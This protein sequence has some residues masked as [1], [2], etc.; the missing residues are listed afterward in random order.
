MQKLRELF[1]EPTEEE[2]LE[3]K[4]KQHSEMMDRAYQADQNLKDFPYIDHIP[5]VCFQNE[6]QA[7]DVLEMNGTWA[8]WGAFLLGPGIAKAHRG[9]RTLTWSTRFAYSRRLAVFLVP[10]FVCWTW[11]T[12]A[13]CQYPNR[14]GNHVNSLPQRAKNYF[15]EKDPTI[16]ENAQKEFYYQMATFDLKKRRSELRELERPRARKVVA[17]EQAYTTK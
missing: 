8:L 15:D 17:M 3:Y 6:R 4:A 9:M 7:R 5:Y 11:F 14:G 1:T 10:G 2:F 12:S 13:Q 16:F